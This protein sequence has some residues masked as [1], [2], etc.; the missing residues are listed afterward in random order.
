MFFT[1]HGV[2]TSGTTY[3]K[4][5]LFS[6]LF[7]FF[8]FF[9]LTGRVRERKSEGSSTSRG[10]FEWVYTDQLH[11]Q[12]HKE[13][14]AKYPAIKALMRPDSHLKWVVLGMVLAQQLACWLV[15]GLAWRWLLFWAYTFGGCVNHS[16]TLAIHISHNTAFSTG[17]TA[18]NRWFAIFTNLPIGIPYSAS[19]KKYHVDYHRYLGGDR[20]DVDVPTCL[21]GQFFCTP[22]C[23]LLWLVLQPLFYSLRLL[24]A[25]P[26]AMT[27]MEVFNAL[28]QLPVDAAILSLW[29]V[30]PM[31]C[32]QAST[33]L[34][35][36]C[37]PSRATLLL[38]TTCSSRAK[39][40]TP[41]M[42]PSTT[43]PSTWA[44]TR[45]TTTSPASPA[46]T[47]PWCGRSLQS[48]TTAGVL[49]PPATAPLVGE[50]A[51]GLCIRG[52]PEALR[53]GEVGVQAGRGPCLR[54][55]ILSGRPGLHRP[56]CTASATHA[57]PP[58]A[59]CRLGCIWPPGS[60]G[61]NHRRPH[62]VA[63]EAHLLVDSLGT[64]PG[65]TR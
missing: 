63:R 23:K 54:V 22:A 35:L 10:D 53:Q 38:S 18:H 42:G 56:H 27:C 39:R 61:S 14:L 11:T 36:G 44:T 29:G 43:S 51:L 58:Q 26:K 16:L 25:H 30:K 12:P 28:V 32:L 4:H 20:L 47:C 40:P 64:F 31:A 33:F 19:F 13:M 55:S 48:T 24:C 45:I 9:F 57:P 15:R 52:L 60:P 6:F 7:F 41:T 5:K 59:Q 1:W 3:S 49:R 34:G 21:E 65:L 50:G 17:A 8:F 37:T 2:N 62:P 46:A